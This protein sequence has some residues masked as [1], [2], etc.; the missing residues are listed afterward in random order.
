MTAPAQLIDDTTDQHRINSHL[1][2]RAAEL[3]IEAM[4]T[5]LDADVYEK[6]SDWLQD[7]TTYA[8][9]EEGWDA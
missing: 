4:D 3:I 5:R 1:L 9:P 6:M 2:M 7:Y 8:S